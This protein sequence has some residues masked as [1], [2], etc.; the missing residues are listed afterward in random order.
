MSSIVYINGKKKNTHFVDE[1]TL[2]LPSSELDE[3]D[4]I[5]VAQTGED[6]MV[7][8]FSASYTFGELGD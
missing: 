6:G 5:S 3:G 7:L 4:I 2:Y 8:S 1:N